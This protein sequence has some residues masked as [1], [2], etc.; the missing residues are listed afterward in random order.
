M[1]LKQAP[2]DVRKAAALYGVHHGKYESVFESVSGP[3]R[4]V[5]KIYPPTGKWFCIIESD[6]EYVA[7]KEWKDIL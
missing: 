5:A 1:N 4:I 3:E 2:I 7:S 6:I